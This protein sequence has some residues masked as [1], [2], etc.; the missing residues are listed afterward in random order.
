MGVLFWY[1]TK[2]WCLVLNVFLNLRKK[3]NCTIKWK[4]MAIKYVLIAFKF[5]VEWHPAWAY[6]CFWRTPSAYLSCKSNQHIIT[7][8]Q[9]EKK[10]DNTQIFNL[11]NNFIIWFFFFLF[12]N[13]IKYLKKNSESVFFLEINEIMKSHQMINTVQ[14]KKMEMVRKLNKHKKQK[15]WSKKETK[16]KWYF[17]SYWYQYGYEYEWE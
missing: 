12:E 13:T 11:Y 8:D 2:R 17:K 4:L 3:L 10:W 7:F 14:S 16:N 1:P 5:C 9:E 15:R 6:S